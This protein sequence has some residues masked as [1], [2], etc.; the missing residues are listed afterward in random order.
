MYFAPS[1]SSSVMYSDSLPEDPLNSLGG[2]FFTRGT[3]FG[4]FSAKLG[5]TYSRRGFNSVRNNTRLRNDYIDFYATPEYEFLEGLRIGAQLQYSQLLYSRFSY[6]SAE[7]GFREK[8]VFPDT[9]TS[10]FGISPTL[11]LEFQDGSGIEFLAQIPNREVRSFFQFSLTVNVDEPKSKADRFAD[12]NEAIRHTR[13][14]K[15]KVLLVRLLTLE[16]SIAAMK[17]SGMNNKSAELE[18]AI[19]NQNKDI[20]NAFRMEFDFCPVYFFYSNHSTNV[21]DGDASV[22][23]DAKGDSTD[24]VFDDCNYYIADFGNLEQDTARFFAG[25]DLV[26][27]GNFDTRKVRRTY[28]RTSFSFGAMK[29]KGCDFI[30]LRDPFPY[31]VKT[32]GSF[33]FKRSPLSFVKRINEKLHDFERKHPSY[34]GDYIRNN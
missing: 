16:H 3:L 27:V 10:F 32:Y 21:R 31:Y 5:G 11:S 28:T 4:Q 18:E 2:G 7:T 9:Y 25:Y 26:Q 23:F 20:V 19:A 12:V 15:K 14:L 8:R 24:F 22:L 30:Q 17:A 34:R 29:I 1:Y 33:V 6:S 13:E